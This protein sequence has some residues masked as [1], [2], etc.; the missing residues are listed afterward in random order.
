[1][2]QS[3]GLGRKL[4]RPTQLAFS[5]IAGSLHTKD[6]QKGRTK[7]DIAVTVYGCD[8]CRDL[9]PPINICRA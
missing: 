6:A 5:A 8:H 7:D 3:E 2:L 9:R 1:M 4:S